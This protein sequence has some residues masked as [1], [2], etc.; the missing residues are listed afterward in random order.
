MGSAAEQGW[1]WVE[2]GG[3][4]EAAALGW[5]WEADSGSGEEA[6]WG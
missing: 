5:G 2:G 4:W 1:G 6:G 3:G